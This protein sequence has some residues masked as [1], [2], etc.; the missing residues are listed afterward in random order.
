M[1]ATTEPRGAEVNLKQLGL[2]AV[3]VA[4]RDVDG[5]RLQFVLETRVVEC[6]F[7]TVFIC[8][9]IYFSAVPNIRFVFA[10]VPNSGPS[11]LLVF[12]RI[13]MLD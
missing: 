13:V 3:Y 9:F 4:A 6:M 12:G 5:L 8:L 10:S 2:W 11:S 7:S 1:T